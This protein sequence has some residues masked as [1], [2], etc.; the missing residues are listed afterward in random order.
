MSENVDYFYKMCLKN[1]D[2]SPQNV[3]ELFSKFVCEMFSWNF[4]QNVYEKF[5]F[6]LKRVWIFIKIIWQTSIFLLKIYLNCFLNLSGINISPE[7]TDKGDLTCSFK[8]NGTDQ[9][10]VL[11][12]FY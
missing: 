3:S 9:D 12:C 7:I 10:S 4:Y 2:V 6:I 11:P 1:V 8:N 5:H